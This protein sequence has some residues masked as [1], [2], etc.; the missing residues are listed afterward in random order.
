MAIFWKQEDISLVHC[1]PVLLASLVVVD[2]EPSLG[3]LLS[4]CFCLRLPGDLHHTQKMSVF[5]IRN[6]S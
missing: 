6:L 4:S 5:Q 1:G 2:Q 3:I